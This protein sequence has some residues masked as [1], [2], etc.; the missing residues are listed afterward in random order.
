MSENKGFEN[1]PDQKD[2]GKVEPRD[3]SNR[4]SRNAEEGE[5]EREVQNVLGEVEIN[6]E[7]LPSKGKFYP[8]DMRIY[9]RAAKTSEVK[10]FSMMDETN[11]LEINEKLNNILSAC[12]NVK[13]IGKRGSYKDIT[14]DDKMFI[15]LSIRDITFIQGEN[16]ISLKHTCDSCGTDNDVR[17]QTVDLQYQ[18]ENETLA[19][20]YDP[21]IRMYRVKSKKHGEIL[22]CSP[23]IGV[24]QEITDY[25][26]S[27]EQKKEKWDK[28]AVQILPYMNLEWR[29]MDDKKIYDVLVDME[30]WNTSKY[31]QVYRLTEMARSGIKQNIEHPCSQCGKKLEIPVEIE[32]GMKGLFIPTVSDSDFE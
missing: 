7:K 21:S 8:G 9:I 29:S 13:R 12:V 11:P 15:I 18:T 24:M 5:I 2:L 23:K 14:E 19:K 3:T 1:F 30:G 22:I 25:A 32:G 26:R 4:K 31:S 16:V 28:A 27:K 17:L 6:F 20:Y 10:D